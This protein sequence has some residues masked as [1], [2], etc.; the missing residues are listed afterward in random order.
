MYIYINIKIKI[1]TYLA[2]HVIKCT[3]LAT[4][5]RTVCSYSAK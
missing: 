4:H 1:H 2:L 3:R 5:I